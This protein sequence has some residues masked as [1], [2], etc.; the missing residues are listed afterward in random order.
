MWTYAPMMV[1]QSIG[2]ILEVLSCKEIIEGMVNEARETLDRAN[3]LF[4][5]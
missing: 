5:E 2:L 1:A 3:A 4:R